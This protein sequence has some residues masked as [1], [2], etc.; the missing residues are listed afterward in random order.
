M[1]KQSQFQ[2]LL[3]QIEVVKAP[4]RR[5]S[6][7]GTSQID[8]TLVTDVPGLPDRAK[9]RTGHVT[10]EKPMII[11][12][13]SLKE[14][15]TGF[16]DNA[17]ELADRMV[18]HYGEV[19][20]GL[21]YQFH[22]EP[23]ETRIELAKPERVI[24][25]LVRDH[26]RDGYHQAVIRGTEKYWQLSIMKFIIEETLASFSAN[27][28]ELSERGF[29]EGEKRVQDNQ[30]REIRFLFKNAA[31]DKSALAQLGKKLKEY[32]LFEQYQDEFF[33]LLK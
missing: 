28:Q 19:L 3:H 2:K 26:D 4:K 29:F 17:K 13:E 23:G 20:R 9:L 25:S 27:V 32:G 11:T 5:L 16:G 8:Y 24:A 1:R 14:R 30:Q 10:A 33:K 31:R 6:T 22:N 21:E 15:F 12:P 18:G 7:F